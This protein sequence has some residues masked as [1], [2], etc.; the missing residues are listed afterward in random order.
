LSRL[1]TEEI[2]FAKNLNCFAKNLNR[3]FAT[4][5]YLQHLWSVWSRPALSAAAGCCRGAAPPQ[6]SEAV[7]KNIN[8]SE[9]AAGTNGVLE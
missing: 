4:Q 9:D 8:S 1:L 6:K 3:C 7:L 2:A 5:A